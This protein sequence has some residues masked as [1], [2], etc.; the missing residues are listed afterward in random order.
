MSLK[1]NFNSINKNFFRT[2]LQSHAT[3]HLKLEYD[4]LPI[5]PVGKNQN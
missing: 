5:F 1:Y 4:M 3:T 2:V